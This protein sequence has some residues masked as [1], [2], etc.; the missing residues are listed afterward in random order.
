MTAIDVHA[1][2]VHVDHATLR[3]DWA[4]AGPA[5]VLLHAGICDWRMWDAEFAAL[6]EDYRVVRYDLRG[7]GDSIPDADPDGLPFAHH[8][9]L[10]AVLAALGIDR[11]ALV[12]CSMGGRVA[13]DATLAVPERVTAVALVCSR[14]SGAVSDRSI[15]PVFD[16]IDEAILRGDVALANELELRL[17]V[18]GPHRA[19]DAVDP[20]LGDWVGSMNLAVLSVGWDGRGEQAFDPPA[21]SR[22]AE[23]ACPVL[24][25]VGDLD[26][27]GTV[28]SGLRMV[29]DIPRAHLIRF[30][31]SAHLPSLEE[32][33]R[34]L[35][36]QSAFLERPDVDVEGDV[37]SPRTQA[38][39]AALS[40][41]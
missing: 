7:V 18:D 6:A 30:P 34:F 11:A 37:E 35:Q 24:V 5:V 40:G 10:V 39:A 26:V 32:H 14:P 31:R 13:L 33:E 19:A 41:G 25:M 17:W 16:R 38:R 36:H 3:G 23:I 2:E 8:D 21:I 12:G 28:E 15:A 29:E 27:A 9:D 1:F 22:L 20:E 4:G